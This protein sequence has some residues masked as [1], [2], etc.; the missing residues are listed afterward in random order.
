MATV[1]DQDGNGHVLW[2]KASGIYIYDI[3]ASWYDVATASWHTS[4]QVENSGGYAFATD[5][6]LEP[7]GNVRV[8]W[9]Q[10]DSAGIYANWTRA[11]SCP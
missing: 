7:N 4:V 5:A 11:F 8:F 9:Y 1:I 3:W 10:M 2:Y 6:L